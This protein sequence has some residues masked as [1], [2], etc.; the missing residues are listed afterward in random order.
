MR[1]NLN[2]MQATRLLSNGQYDVIVR[3]DDPGNCVYLDANNCFKRA[4]ADIHY[5][6]SLNAEMHVMQEDVLKSW[7]AYC[8]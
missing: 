3:S 2:L 4:P 6:G 8:L 1:Q 5:Q 7:T